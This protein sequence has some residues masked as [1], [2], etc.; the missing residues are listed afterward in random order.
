M[1]K[2][3]WQALLALVT[4]GSS[5]AA[6]PLAQADTLTVGTTAQT[7]PTSYR[8]D[9][10]LT[11][12]DVAVAKTVGKE[13]GAKVKFKVVGDVPSLFGELD[14][15]NIDTIANSITVLPARE[16]KY[17]FSP[18]YSYYAAQIA[19]LKDS[20]YHTLKDLAGKTV[21]APVGSSNIDLLEKYDSRIKIK[22]YDDRNAVFTDANNGTVAG[23]LN[24]RQF[25]QETVKKQHLNLRIVKGVAGWNVTAFPFAK[26]KQAQAK[27]K[28]FDKALT[29]LKQDGTLAKLSKQ[30]YNGADV[31][32]KSLQDQ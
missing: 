23:V 32:K 26:D 1:K 29:K 16:K 25:I 6:A 31:T 18:A 4:L 5:L 12:F 15:G 30:F 24:Q 14:Q 17:H 20:K 10:K 28:R 3:K 21:A 7:Y 19:V 11:G 27:Q 2:M 22:K 9:G 13:M 8:K